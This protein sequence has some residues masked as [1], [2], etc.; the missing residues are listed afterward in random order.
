MAKIADQCSIQTRMLNSTKVQLY[1]HPRT[2]VDR[3]LA[4][5]KMIAILEN[6]QNLHLRQ[7]EIT[8]IMTDD[9]QKSV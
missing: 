1:I 3:R 2:Q 7:A 9:E 4:Q 6:T 8:H 5:E